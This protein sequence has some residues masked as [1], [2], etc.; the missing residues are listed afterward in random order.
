VNHVSGV[1]VGGLLLGC[2]RRN[3][4]SLAVTGAVYVGVGSVGNLGVEP[5]PKMSTPVDSDPLWAVSPIE[6]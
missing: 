1:L 5:E 2:P 6:F 3:G 4:T